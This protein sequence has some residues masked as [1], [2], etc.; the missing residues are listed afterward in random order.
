M[1]PHAL[2]AESPTRSALADPT[3]TTS[4]L[5]LGTIPR[6]TTLTVPA[7]GI[8]DIVACLAQG[9]Q[10]IADRD[11][12]IG[13]HFGLSAGEAPSIVIGPEALMRGDA[14]VGASVGASVSGG[15]HVD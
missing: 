2:G 14:G 4:V 10:G 3:L 6:A 1:H 11:A 8:Y 9:S 5:F 13:G 15:V 12:E 7:T